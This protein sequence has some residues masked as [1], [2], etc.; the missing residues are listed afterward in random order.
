MNRSP[1]SLV[2][3]A[4]VLFA[5]TLTGVIWGPRVTAGLRLCPAPTLAAFDGA[6]ASGRQA[7]AAA[8]RTGGRIFEAACAQCHGPRGKG[9]PQPTVGFVLPLPDLSDCNFTREPDADWF[10]VIHD[11]GPGPRLRQADARLRRGTHA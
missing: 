8:Q 7:P 1:I 6:T 4:V 9:A 2:S 5:C 3:S 10:A 11:G